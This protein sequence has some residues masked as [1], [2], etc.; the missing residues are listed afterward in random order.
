MN[1]KVD[2]GTHF[3]LLLPDTKIASY[4]PAHRVWINH[5]LAL[6]YCLE[7]SSRYIFSRLCGSSF[8]RMRPGKKEA[9]SG[10][11]IAELIDLS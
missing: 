10:T 11:G 2:L 1:C 3:M 7:D 4:G 6:Q 8:L 5:C 9:L